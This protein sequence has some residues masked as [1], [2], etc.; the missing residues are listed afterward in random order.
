MDVDVHHPTTHQG[1]HFLSSLKQQ[2]Y[3]YNQINTACSALGA[4]I[5]IGTLSRWGTLP[6]VKRF[7]KGVFESQPFFPKHYFVWDV[8]S[9]FNT[10]RELGDP[11]Q[12][13][14]PTLTKKLCMLLVLLSG[15]QRCQTIHTIDVFDLI[16]IEDCL[17]IPI[18]A[19]IKQTKP[20]RHMEPLKFVPFL[21]EPKLC[22]VQHI[23][24]YLKKTA[25]L[26]QCSSLFLSYV[27]PHKAVSRDTIRRWCK[28]VLRSS[29]IDINK[30]TSHSS[31]SAATSKAKQK[32]ISLTAISK[33]AGWSSER[34][35]ALHYD[36]EIVSNKDNVFQLNIM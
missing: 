11:H 19:K 3:T 24:Q 13:D 35:F 7:M 30:Y 10:F 28:D 34:T 29:G 6:I 22:V 2:G 33:Y 12:L 31:R 5:N 1:L 14:L 4:I 25:P 9:V 20:S 18:M 32:G 15:G 8:S 17:C 16:I 21:K 23:T 36:K 27:K 26:R